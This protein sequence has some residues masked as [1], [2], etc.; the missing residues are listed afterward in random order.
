LI[1]QEHKIY[2]KTLETYNQWV[3]NQK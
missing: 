2:P 3:V 1:E